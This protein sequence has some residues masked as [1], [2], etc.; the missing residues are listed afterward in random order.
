MAVN[1]KYQEQMNGVEFNGSFEKETI[2]KLLEFQHK[3]K[4]RIIN[5]KKSAK[6]IA[7]AAAI[8]SLLVI[9]AFAISVLLTPDEVADYLGQSDAVEAFENKDAQVVNQTV[10]NNGFVFTLE[11]IAQGTELQYFGS[12]AIEAQRSYVVIA[13]Q[14]ADGSTITDDDSISFVPLFEGNEPW[15]VNGFLFEGASVHR[16]VKDNVLYYLWDFT[17]LQ[18]FADR[19]IYFAGF[20]GVAPHNGIFVMNDS[21]EV[22]FNS[23]YDGTKVMFELELDVSKADPAKA[24]ELIN[25]I[26]H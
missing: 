13:M 25:N 15:R 3:R 24:E 14:R 12:N 2:V 7:V 20:E 6:I 21:G 23:A 17:D 4:G 9:T 22:E 5:M 26:G 18:V 19:K 1:Q 8:T 10:E 16:M 11:G